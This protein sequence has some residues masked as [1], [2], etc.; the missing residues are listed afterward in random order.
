MTEN[1]FYKDKQQ[2][3]PE[4]LPIAAP[5]SQHLLCHRCIP[6]RSSSCSTLAP[7][8]QQL[9]QMLTGVYALRHEPFP[10]SRRRLIYNDD[11]KIIHSAAEKF[12]SL[13]PYLVSGKNME[14][15]EVVWDKEQIDIP[16]AAKLRVYAGLL[17]DEAKGLWRISLLVSTLLY[18][19]ILDLTDYKNGNLDLTDKKEMFTTVENEIVKLGLE[20]VGLGNLKPLVDGKGIMDALRLKSASTDVGRWQRKVRQWQLAHPQATKEECI[21]WIKACEDRKRKIDTL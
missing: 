4:L 3:Q 8:Q 19:N 6:N 9:L 5:P 1:K 17:L 13:I 14:A 20:E 15:I 7:A 12:V 11:V 18:P 21:D 16:I 10:P 2:V